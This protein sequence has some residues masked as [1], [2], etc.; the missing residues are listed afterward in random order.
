MDFTP[1]RSLGANT[2]RR[3][4]CRMNCTRRGVGNHVLW[5]PAA[6][7]L[8][9]RTRVDTPWRRRKRYQRLDAQVDRRVF[10]RLIGKY[11]ITMA[12]ER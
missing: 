9:G 12:H 3:D 8:L 5:F 2:P 1:V 11:E 10:Y 7:R 6:I 4:T